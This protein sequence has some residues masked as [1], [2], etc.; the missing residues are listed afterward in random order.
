VRIRVG[1]G[2]EEKMKHVRKKRW[3]AACAAMS[4]L[5]IVGCQTFAPGDDEKGKQLREPANK[6]LTAIEQY[7]QENGRY[8]NSL[9]ELVPKYVDRLPDEPTLRIDEYSSTLRF[10]YSRE[11]PQ[12]GRI[13]CIAHFGTTDWQCEE[14]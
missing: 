8:P 10:A 12:L 9:Y 13:V 14:K 7:K 4:A 1:M 5:L 6:V 3:S 11:W 2:A